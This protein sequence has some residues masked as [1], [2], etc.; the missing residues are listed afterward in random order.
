M[1]Y[2]ALAKGD[3]VKVS[4]EEISVLEAQA[5]DKF[6][7]YELVVDE[8]DPDNEPATP[9]EADVILTVR[10]KGFSEDTIVTVD[11]SS[12]PTTLIDKNTLQA[13]AYAHAD[14]A[15]D[16][17]PTGEYAVLA[18]DDD[19]EITSDPEEAPTFV[20]GDSHRPGI[21]ST[22][23]ADGDTNI[24]ADIFPRVT[25]SEAMNTSTLNVACVL[26]DADGNGVPLSEVTYS[27]GNTV[28][29]L[30]PA[31]NLTLG[32]TYKVRV[33]TG[34]RDTSGNRLAEQFEMANGFTVVPPDTIPPTVVSTNPANGA[35]SVDVETSIAVT[36]S[37]AMDTT[38]F[39]EGVLSL[40]DS[41]GD[42]VSLSGLGI[43]WSEGDTVATISPTSPLDAGATYKIRVTTGAKD[44]NGNALA[45]QFEQGGGFSTAS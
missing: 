13:I 24:G 32:A 25:F 15:D 28:A 35:G 36:F 41:G 39:T 11:G 10:G 16:P 9:I 18:Q 34:A 42:P 12:V 26:V 37:E 43:V 6:G 8:I 23:P 44:A 31:S 38:S 7:D 30:H 19:A 40:R 21:V 17:I 1:V 20:I 33:L 3:M 14:F 2:Q 27:A 4:P 29:S 22:N 45:E 5:P